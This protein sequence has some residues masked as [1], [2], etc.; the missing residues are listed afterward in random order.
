LAHKGK[1]EQKAAPKQGG[2]GKNGSEKKV[3]EKRSRK[4]R[5]KFDVGRI[6]GRSEKICDRRGGEVIETRLRRGG[7][8]LGPLEEQTAGLGHQ[9]KKVAAEGKSPSQIEKEKVRYQS[10]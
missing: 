1:K 6:G 4:G 3:L 2:N 9:I 8:E 10:K 7:R 5:V